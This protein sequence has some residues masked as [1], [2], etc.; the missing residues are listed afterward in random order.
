MRVFFAITFE[1][2][3]KTLL[4]NFIQSQKS[5]NTI[6][7]IY[8]TK[9]DH[10]HITL[11][12]LSDID[13]D[14]LSDLINNVES[15][16]RQHKISSFIL[17]S[18]DILL[19]STSD[20]KVLTVEIA[21]NDSLMKLVELINTETKYLGFEAEKRAFKPHI[22]LGRIKNT[23]LSPLPNLSIPP[24]EIPV[25]QIILF[26]SKPTEDGSHYIER[27]VFNFPI[28]KETHDL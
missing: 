28:T 27:Y 7:N 25:K 17:N 5:K 14:K 3:I 6:E 9:P 1:L 18:K 13:E 20:S 11:R 26:E 24:L 10:L 15:Q 19:F 16:L 23:L 8:W 2:P 22:T 21:L 4:T 12:F